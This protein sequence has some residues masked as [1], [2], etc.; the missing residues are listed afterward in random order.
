MTETLAHETIHVLMGRVMADVGAVAK[1]ERNSQQ[2]FNFRG[3][4]GVLNAVGPAMR[5]HGVFPVARLI[6][7]DTQTVEVGQKRT[8]M[9]HVTL[10]VDYQ[11]HGPAG[12]HVHT[13]VVA[14]AMDS[15]DKTVSK[16]WSVALRT[17]LLQVFAIP[18]DEPDP[19]GQSYERSPTRDLPAEAQ[20]IANESEAA[21]S[22]DEVKAVWRNAS[23]S[24]LLDVD[25][26]DPLGE[27]VPLRDLLKARG[28]ALQVNDEPE[29]VDEPEAA[30]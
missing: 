24:D 15:G 13:E 27:I 6:H 14:E 28:D 19:D 4:D 1:S 3:I 11:F 22:L 5:K 30:Q 21:T 12:D 23:S 8:Q 20:R 26:T 16:A 10:R 9:A 18:T 29:E 2:G 17:A 7:C 25:V